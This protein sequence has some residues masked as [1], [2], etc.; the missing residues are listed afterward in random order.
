MCCQVVNL[1]SL[2]TVAR[3]FIYW[4]TYLE[5]FVICVG[6]IYICILKNLSLNKSLYQNTEIAIFHC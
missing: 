1:V 2:K 4:I 5:Y 3:H 6:S